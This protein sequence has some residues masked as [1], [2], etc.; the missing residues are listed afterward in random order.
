MQKAQEL[1]ELLSKEPKYLES[2][3]KEGIDTEA[4]LISTMI[5]DE[6][7]MIADV[8]PEPDSL[9]KLLTARELI[10][11]IELKGHYVHLMESEETIKKALKE[12]Q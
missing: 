11:G 1:A 7:D 6:W 4:E 2:L 9:T 8:G 5:D 3:E 12:F 10:K